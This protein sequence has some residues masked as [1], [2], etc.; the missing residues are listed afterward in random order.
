MTA[1][2][3]TANGGPLRLLAP[4]FATLGNTTLVSLACRLALALPFWRSGA[5]KWDAFAGLKLSPDPLSSGIAEQGFFS[6][7]PVTTL[8]FENEFKLH[9]PG[10]PYPYPL[11]GLMGALSGIGEI[12]LPVLL[13]LGLFTRFAALALLG[14][15][16]IIQLTV[17]T[18]WP[19][20]LMWAALAL[21]VIHAGPGRIAL[22]A[23]VQR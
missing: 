21:A 6:L 14:M 22:D 7:S 2:L 3:A 9:L 20:H 13:V 5:N 10:G 8:L 23:I 16:V 1:S 4:V 12:V 15:T 17:P 18:G 11:P 19:T